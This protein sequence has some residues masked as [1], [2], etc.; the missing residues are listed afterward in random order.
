[1]QSPTNTLDVCAERNVKGLY[2]KAMKG[3]KRETEKL[4]GCGT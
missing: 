2:K 3:E 1:M 4:E